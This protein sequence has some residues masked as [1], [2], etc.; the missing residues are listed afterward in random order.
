M[1]P[2]AL[3]ALPVVNSLPDYARAGATT[4]AAMIGG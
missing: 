2:V 4:F 3:A 1:L